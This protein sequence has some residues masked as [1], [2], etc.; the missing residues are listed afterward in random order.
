[1]ELFKALLGG[2]PGAGPARHDHLHRE[3]AGHLGRGAEERL[4]PV[5][6]DGGGQQAGGRPAAGQ[7]T[8]TAVNEISRIFTMPCPDL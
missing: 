7:V 4:L 2:A 1:M 6:E 8:T 5:Q 3:E